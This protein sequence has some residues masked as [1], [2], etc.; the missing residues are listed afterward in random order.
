MSTAPP[1]RRCQSSL[2]HWTSVPSVGVWA[3][4]TEPCCW[5]GAGTE[6]LQVMNSAGNNMDRHRH[7]PALLSLSLIKTLQ[8]SHQV[9]VSVLCRSVFGWHLLDVSFFDELVGRVNDVLLSPEPLVHLQQLV[10]LLLKTHRMTRTDTREWEDQTEP[11]ATRQQMES[12][13]Y[14]LRLQFT[15]C[16]FI[17]FEFV[18]EKDYA[19]STGGVTTTFWWNILVRIWIR[20]RMRDFYSPL[21]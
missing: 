14:Q 12:F 4:S 15:R 3:R 21:S 11:W 5:T 20:G 6:T 16:I 18:C 9:E 10:H 1:C 13:Y 8:P 2:W 19:K 7:P 17:S